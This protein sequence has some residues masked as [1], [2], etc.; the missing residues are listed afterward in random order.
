[1]VRSVAMTRPPRSRVVCLESAPR[2]A[3][4]PG[5]PS[6]PPGVTVPVRR[7][8]R[9]LRDWRGG[10]PRVNRAAAGTTTAA[11]FPLSGAGPWAEPATHRGSSVARRVFRREDPPMDVA[12]GLGWLRPHLDVIAETYAASRTDMEPIP[13]F[14]HTLAHV[15]DEPSYERIQSFFDGEHDAVYGLGAGERARTQLRDALEAEMDQSRG[16]ANS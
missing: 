10:G 7:S 5:V 12:E 11:L 9:H 2:G 4:W 13:A 6:H 1:M 15:L 3:S 14:E 8:E 16:A